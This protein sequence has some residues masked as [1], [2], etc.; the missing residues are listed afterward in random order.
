MKQPGRARICLRAKVSLFISAPEVLNLY[1]RLWELH[2][3]D[4]HG[5]VH[6]PLQ[7]RDH[8]QAQRPLT[9]LA[10]LTS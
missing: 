5:R 1:S 8:L 3:P 10:K 4:N 6:V 2:V 7:P 9:A